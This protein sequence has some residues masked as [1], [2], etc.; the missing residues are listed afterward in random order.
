MSHEGKKLFG[1][2]SGIV[3]GTLL[4]YALAVAAVIW[5]GVTVLRWMGVL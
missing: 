1:L 2:V 4:F 3:V 5:V